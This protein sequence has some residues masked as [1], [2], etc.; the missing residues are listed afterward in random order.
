LS[1]ELFGVAQTVRAVT[2]S[3]TVQHRT[4]SRGGNSLRA[5]SI[6]KNRMRQ[7]EDGTVQIH[8]EVTADERARYMHAANF[9]MLTICF[10]VAANLY[11]NRL[12]EQW[13]T[14]VR[15]WSGLSPDDPAAKMP[16]TF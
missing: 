8:R 13:N 10:A 11:G 6:A 7:L 14:L 5:I 15:E 12:V 9:L 1:S 16:R 2:F 4:V 3:W